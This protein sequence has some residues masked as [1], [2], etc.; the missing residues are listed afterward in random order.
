[1]GGYDLV[2]KNIMKNTEIRRHIKWGLLKLNNLTY[3]ELVKFEKY[4]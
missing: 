3:L 1:M 2:L 4:K